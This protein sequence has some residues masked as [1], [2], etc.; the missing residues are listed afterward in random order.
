MR[1]RGRIGSCPCSGFEG[2]S[3]RCPLLDQGRNTGS[4]V[5][6]APGWDGDRCADVKGSH[7]CSP[8]CGEMAS[9]RR[10]SALLVTLGHG[11]P[12]QQGLAS[13]AEWCHLA[14]DR[15]YLAPLEQVCRSPSWELRL[16]PWGSQWPG[17]RAGAS[18]GQGLDTALCTCCRWEPR[19]DARD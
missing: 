10:S 13:S 6:R 2:G 5:S 9:F 18:G 8:R 16:L 11:H 3:A 4:S 1:E 15:G 12:D 17:A 19:L 14:L 7:V